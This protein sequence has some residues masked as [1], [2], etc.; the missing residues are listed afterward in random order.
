MSYTTHHLAT[1]TQRQDGSID[2]HLSEAAEQHS[3]LLPIVPKPPHQGGGLR[4]IVPKPGP[5]VLAP[6]VPQQSSYGQGQGLRPIVPKPGPGVIS[7]LVPQQGSG[8][9]PIVPKPGP[10]VL[11]PLVPG[12]NVS[13]PVPGSSVQH[14]V[15]LIGGAGEA[16]LTA[17]GHRLANFNPNSVCKYN[18]GYGSTCSQGC[19]WRSSV[20]F[21]CPRERGCND[22]RYFG[23]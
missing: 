19:G 10:G 1:V 12:S 2:L 9:N 11:A 17:S 6:L 5:G 22:Y 21:Y 18:C 14:P 7:P 13:W 16:S 3:G 23:Y 8:L 4:P 20:P 15:P